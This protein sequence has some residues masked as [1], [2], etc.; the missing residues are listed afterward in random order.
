[1]DR[2]RKYKFIYRKTGGYSHPYILLDGVSSAGK[3]TIA[4]FFVKKGYFISKADD[5]PARDIR[6]KIQ[7]Q[8][9]LN[10]YYS[11]AQM[12]KIS[13]DV[14]A[15][16]QHDEAMK[17]KLVMYDDITQTVALKYPDDNIFIIIIY[18]SLNNLIRNILNR[19]FTEPRLSLGA[20]TQFSKRFN[21]TNQSDDTIDNVNRADFLNELEEKMKYLFESYEKLKKFVYDIFEQ[22]EITDDETHGIK[23]RDT[24]RSDYILNTTNKTREEISLELEQFIS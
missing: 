15:K 13:E 19:R 17:H 6:I 4:D 14:I 5:I 8:L 12:R 18:T 7:Q 1:M 20:F 3:S 21:K 11:E 23:L 16:I 10:Q 24:Y 22:M 2:P 9:D